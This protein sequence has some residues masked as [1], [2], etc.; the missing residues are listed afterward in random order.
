MNREE[1]ER[2]MRKPWAFRKKRCKKIPDSPHL[3]DKKRWV[4][5]P[6]RALHWFGSSSN[7]LRS[8]PQSLLEACVTR[9]HVADSTQGLSINSMQMYSEDKRRCVR[10]R[11][12]GDGNFYTTSHTHTPVPPSVVSTIAHGTAVISRAVLYCFWS[13]ISHISNI[14]AR[15]EGV[16]LVKIVRSKIKQQPVGGITLTPGSGRNY[17][18]TKYKCV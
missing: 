6:L 7:W 11:P 2:A 8:T 14:D 5:N 17:V 10:Q 4:S 18:Q 15:D 16:N 12:A 3:S 1:K 9:C 13:N